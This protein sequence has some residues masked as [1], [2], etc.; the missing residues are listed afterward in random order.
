MAQLGKRYVY[1]SA[2]PN[3][4]DCSGLMVFAY[5]KVGISLPH[6]AYQMGYSVGVKRTRAE[7]Q[8]GDLVFWNTVA[9]SDLCDHVGIYMGNGQAVHAS[10]GSG[11]VVVS[12]IDSGYY[13][14]N[15]SWGRNVLD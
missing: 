12:T 3:T 8:R 7:L 14:K 4:F 1:G 11:K 10:S 15:F 2:G 6:S 13:Q 5:A 9:D